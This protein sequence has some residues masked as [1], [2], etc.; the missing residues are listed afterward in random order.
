MPRVNSFIHEY[1]FNSH[2]LLFRSESIARGGE[3]MKYLALA[4]VVFI[5]GCEKPI[6]EARTPKVVP[7]AVQASSLTFP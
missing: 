6:K 5:L 2:G 4:L 3:V 1:E 7:A